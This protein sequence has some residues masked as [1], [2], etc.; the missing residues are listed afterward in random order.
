MLP[1]VRDPRFAI[2]LARAYNAWLCERWLSPRTD[3]AG[4]ARRL[5]AATRRR[6][7][8]TSAGTPAIAEFCCIYL[9]ACGLKPLYGHQQYEPI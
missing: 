4:R 2:A 9:P 1:M 3:A 5:P 8:P 7:P 6:A